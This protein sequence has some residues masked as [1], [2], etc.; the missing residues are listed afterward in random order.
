MAGPNRNRFRLSIPFWRP[1]SEADH[2][3]NLREIE[4]AYGESLINLEVVARVRKAATQSINHATVTK[5]LLDTVVEDEFKFFDAATNSLVV[6]RGLGGAYFVRGRLMYPAA[7]YTNMQ[8]AIRHNIDGTN[9]ANPAQEG[10][11]ETLTV[12]LGIKNAFAQYHFDEGDRVELWAYQESGAARNLVVENSP[13]TV[14]ASFAY[15]SPFLEM[16]RFAVKG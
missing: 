9:Y 5:V 10:E 15:F 16:W 3:A 8:A 14:A 6:P 2:F 11:A 13:T 1:R 7:N 12:A 4:R